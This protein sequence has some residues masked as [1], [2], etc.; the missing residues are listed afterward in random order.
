MDFFGA[1]GGVSRVLLSI[2]GIFYGGYANFW[3]AFALNGL[4]YKVKSNKEIFRISKKNIGNL[5]AMK[6]PL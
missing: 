4:L 3:S 2:C 6:L 1:L 5:Q